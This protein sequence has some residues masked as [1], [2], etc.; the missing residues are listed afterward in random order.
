M[1]PMRGLADL[2]FQTSCLGCSRPVKGGMCKV[3]FAALERIGPKVCARCGRP[4]ASAGSCPDCTGR[5]LHFDFARQAAKFSPLIRRAIHQFKYSGSTHLA[6]FLAA[7]VVELAQALELES[8][9]VTWVP[10]STK[11]MRST[12][13]DHGKLLCDLV[14]KAL[15][16][17]ALPLL[18]RTRHS[19]PQMTIP[20]D[21]RRTNLVGAFVAVLPPPETVVFIDDVYTT[22][23][24][25][26]EAARALK[27]AGAVRVPVLCA[28]RSFETL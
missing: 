3:C 27:A 25:A 9:T 11:R 15:G 5:E 17:R 12:G 28:A 10:A 16:T 14:A 13:V 22:G 26:T 20:P 21:A 1:A 18:A 23:S 8:A 7:L 2:L 4:D 6:V 19:A 24:T